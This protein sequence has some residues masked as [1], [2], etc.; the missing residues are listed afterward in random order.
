MSISTL[1]KGDYDDDDDDNNNNNNNNNNTIKTFSL[2]HYSVKLRHYWGVIL[3]KASFVN[4]AKI[5]VWGARL[6]FFFFF[7]GGRSGCFRKLVYFC[8]YRWG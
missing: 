6:I 5:F 4:L 3:I 8:C 2:L 7:L 1:H